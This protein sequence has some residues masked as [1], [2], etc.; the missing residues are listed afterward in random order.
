MPEIGDRRPR[1]CLGAGR[2]RG[3]TRGHPAGGDASL[4]MPAIERFFPMQYAL[5]EL[6]R[7]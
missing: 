5:L 2:E 6:P 4:S 1:L 3:G 7:Q